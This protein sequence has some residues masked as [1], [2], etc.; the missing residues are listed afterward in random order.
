MMRWPWTAAKHPRVSRGDLDKELN[1]S[2]AKLEEAN[3]QAL[4][5]VQAL[6]A[7]IQQG[8]KNEHG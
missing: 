7:Q 2:V 5:A 1:R 6:L 4:A 3:T 8:E